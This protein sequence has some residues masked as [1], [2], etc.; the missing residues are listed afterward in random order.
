MCLIPSFP[1]LLAR[2]NLKAWRG[3]W[4]LALE[5]QPPD[6][7]QSDEAGLT[8]CQAVLS[9]RSNAGSATDSRWYG[10]AEYVFL[11]GDFATVCVNWEFHVAA[12]PVSIDL[13]CIPSTLGATPFEGSQA[14]SVLSKHDFLIRSGYLVFGATGDAVSSPDDCIRLDVVTGFQSLD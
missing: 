7:E 8:R 4:K 13:A 1:P 12:V 6:A 9:H 10:A 14:P 3:V 11:A 2:N 5:G